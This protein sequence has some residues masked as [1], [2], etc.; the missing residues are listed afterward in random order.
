[1]PTRGQ[2]ALLWA[3]LELHAVLREIV[4]EAAR[5]GRTTGDVREDEWTESPEKV[6][7]A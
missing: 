6:N 1:V 4:L 7:V 2:L 5:G 3:P